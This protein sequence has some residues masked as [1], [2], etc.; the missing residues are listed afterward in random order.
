MINSIQKSSHRGQTLDK[1]L[2]SYKRAST[3]SKE[4]HYGKDEVEGEGNRIP[5]WFSIHRQPTTC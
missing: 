3:M 5:A 4:L 1:L 2:S